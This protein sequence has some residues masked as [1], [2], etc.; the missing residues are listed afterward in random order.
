MRDIFTAGIAL[1]LHLIL[2]AFRQFLITVCFATSIC[3]LRE[4]A[5]H[6][7]PHTAERCQMF[8]HRLISFTNFNAHFLYSLTI[9]MLHYNPRR[10]SSIYMPIFRRTNCNITASDIVTHCKRLYSM[11]DENLLQ[12]ALIQHTVEPFT[13]SDGTRCCDNKICSPEDGHVVAR[14][15]S[16]IVM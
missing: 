16:R 4:T 11:P 9:C 8:L 6:F 14:N 5:V 1:L 7:T 13:E 15:I 3:V 12:P 10:V 2:S